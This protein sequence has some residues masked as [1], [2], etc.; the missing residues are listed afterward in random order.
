MIKPASDEVPG[1]LQMSLTTLKKSILAA[2]LATLAPQVFAQTLRPNNPGESPES[3]STLQYDSSPFD[4][5]VNRLPINYVGVDVGTLLL[6]LKARVQNSKKDEFETTEAYRLRVEKQ[7]AT[8]ILGSLN[9]DSVMSTRANL[10]ATYNADQELMSVMVIPHTSE[11]VTFPGYKDRI[12]RAEIKLDVPTAKRTKENL[13]ALIVF[14]LPRCMDSYAFCALAELSY[15]STVVRAD[16]LEVW[17][18]DRSTGQVYSKRG[19]DEG[20]VGTPG[21][22]KLA[23][24]RRL[25]DAGRN[26]EALLEL[27]K[28]INIEPTN[29]EAF[30][31]VGQIYMARAEIDPAI[32]ALKTA[33]FWDPKLISAHILLGRIFLDLGDLSEATKYS[34]NALMLDPDNENAVM[35]RTRIRKGKP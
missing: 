2:A 21:D 9:Y 20:V 31:F 29:A 24:V 33:V 5:S 4:R 8:P 30:F 7:H 6:R 12:F 17:F 35:L 15:G 16:L 32:A 27:R 10:S 23:V 28:I 3:Q 22:P 34:V 25:Y 1:F 18:Y 19:A 26:E 14:S 11:S 13:A